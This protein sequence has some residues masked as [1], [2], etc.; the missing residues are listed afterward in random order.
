MFK[1]WS[2]DTQSPAVSRAIHWEKWATKPGPEMTSWVITGSTQH[3]RQ[4]EK[5]H[6]SGCKKYKAYLSWVA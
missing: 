2:K 4:A 1:D 5:W 6:F 3:G